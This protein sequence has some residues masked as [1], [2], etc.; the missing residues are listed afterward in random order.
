MERSGRWA[1]TP[2]S[3]GGRKP[4]R[5][6]TNQQAGDEHTRCLLEISEERLPTRATARLCGEQ[7]DQH[8]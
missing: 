6:A 5:A 7:R 1:K 4:S 3:T 8:P 2:V